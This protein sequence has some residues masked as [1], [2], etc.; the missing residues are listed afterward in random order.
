MNI[1]LLNW[2]DMKNQWSGGAE[3]Y[4]T[5][6]A[7]RWVT[8]G[9]QVTFFC[10]QNYLHNLPPEETIDGIKIIRRGGRYTLYLWFIW[11]YFT[12]FRGRFD[13][14]VD[15]VNGIPFFT[16]LFASEPVVALLFHVHD[17][18]FFIELP[19][20]MS[21]VGYAI[22]RYVFPLVYKKNHLVAI[23]ST[24]KWDL[25]RLGL[26]EDQIKIVY[27][28]VDHVNHQLP[29]SR[30]RKFSR[31]TIL[32]L[33]KIKKYKRVDLLVK[34]MPEI[35]QHVPKARLLIAGWGTDGP[36]LADAS[37]Q[38]EVRKRVKILGPVSESEKRSLM[39]SSWVCA[40]PSLHEG[41]GIPVIEGNLY[42][43]P[44]VAFRVPGLAESIK[45]GTTGLL[46]DTDEEFIHSLIEVLTNSQLRR[47]LEAA[48]RPWAA[49]FTWDKSA[50]QFITLIK[51]QL[52]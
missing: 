52:K 43:T 9:H 34:F 29:K 35:L 50:K 8:M 42:G 33:G 40:N 39:S 47:R 31:P 41:W 19:F 1:L 17:M 15:S 45:D 3:I 48:A 11:Y 5:E 46:A 21:V 18:Q 36:Y 51:S 6:L 30:I 10:G 49:N 25:V 24:T 23:S 44:S 16:P 37:M 4:V 14:I 26:S 22:E 12:R 20:P 28:G 38:S 2:R 32:Y 7:K 13:I 27:P